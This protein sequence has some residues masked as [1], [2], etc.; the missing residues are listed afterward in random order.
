VRLLGSLTCLSLSKHGDRIVIDE[1]DTGPAALDCPVEA[2]SR[3]QAMDTVVC[4]GG[5][6]GGDTG[7]SGIVFRAIQISVRARLP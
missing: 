6:I 7:P 3:N 5:A 2:L 1:D 4:S